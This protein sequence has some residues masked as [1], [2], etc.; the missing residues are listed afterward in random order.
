MSMGSAPAQAPNDDRLHVLVDCTG[1][2][3]DL[4]SALDAVTELSFERNALYILIG[5]EARLSEELGKLAHDSEFLDIHDLGAE[6]NA[7]DYSAQYLVRNPRSAYVSAAPAR[8]I[9]DALRAHQALLP[10]VQHPIQCAIVPVVKSTNEA[11]R[12]AVL[13]DASEARHDP[14]STARELIALADPVARWFGAQ[15]DHR[16]GVLASDTL[17]R[18]TCPDT[19]RLVDE[20]QGLGRD[21]FSKGVVTPQ[22][23]MLGA[24]DIAL[25]AGPTGPVFVRTLEATFVAADALIRRET[26]GVRGRL[27]VRFFRDRLEK[28]RDYGNIESYGGSPMLGP[29]APVVMLQAFASAR[30]WYNAIRLTRKMHRSEYIEKARVRLEEMHAAGPVSGGE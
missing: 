21:V 24:V 13:V 15:H 28:L 11:D 23:L 7:S 14:P 4:L 10:H 12:Y 22:D 25:S 6:R 3:E 9:S 5:D 16:I 20:L 30:A 27:G 19:L 26:Q 8:V 18:V 1:P 2:I 17:H 29:V